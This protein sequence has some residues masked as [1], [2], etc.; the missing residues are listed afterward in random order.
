MTR[1]VYLLLFIT[2]TGIPTIELQDYTNNIKN[3]YA[4]AI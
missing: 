2:F 4:K 1:P 3:E